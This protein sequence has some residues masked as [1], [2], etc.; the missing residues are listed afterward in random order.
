MNIIDSL[1][2]KIKE[3]NNP[4]VMGLDPALKHLPDFLKEKYNL[5]ESLEKL[6]DAILEFNKS[7]I[8]AVYDI[9]PAV[10][11]NLAFYE[12]YGA[13]GIELFIETCEYARQ[14]GMLIV[15]DGKRNDIGTTAQS[16]AE[17]Y[18]GK[19]YDI[20]MLT[21]N[22][23][24]G[25]DGIKPFIDVAEKLEFSKGIFVLVKTSNKSSG[26]LQDL[27]LEDG[28][29][30]YEAVASL[31]DTWGESSVGKYG[32][33]TVGAVVGA[34]Y[35]EQLANLRSKMPK[36][37][38]LIP[39]YGAQGGGAKDIVGGFNKDGLGAIVN[40]SRSLMCA[41]KSEMW[42]DKFVEEDYAKATRAEAMRMRD[43]INSVLNK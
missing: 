37:Y 4:T 27:K 18:F 11:P 41:Y 26:Q 29:T 8:D 19:Y 1:I 32:Y 5:N 23:Y 9:I 40:A 28:R 39:G 33:S 3:K 6:P 43:D 30:I 17:A 36:A 20:D 12:V 10:K 42:K 22:P 14:K 34:T 15:T 31:V 25:E 2:E 21:V 24:L 38:I 35:P 13:K 16:Y 7:L